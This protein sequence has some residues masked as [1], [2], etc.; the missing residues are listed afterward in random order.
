MQLGEREGLLRANP[1]WA[2][3]PRELRFDLPLALFLG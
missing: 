2:A 1:N 3:S